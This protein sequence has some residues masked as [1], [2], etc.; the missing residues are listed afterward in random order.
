MLT[1][2]ETGFMVAR[3]A[4]EKA[5]LVRIGADI[6]SYRGVT[7]HISV[8]PDNPQ[9]VATVVEIG[10]GSPCYLHVAAA[11]HRIADEFTRKHDVGPSPCAP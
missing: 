1:P 9:G 3:N 5:E 7:I 8:N 2:N 10:P 4:D 6:A 11:L